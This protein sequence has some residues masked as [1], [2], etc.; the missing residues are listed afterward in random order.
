MSDN[1]GVIVNSPR[2]PQLKLL[3]REGMLSRVKLETFRRLSTTELKC[4]L[5]PGERGCLKARPDG[6]VLDGHHRLTVLAERGENIHQLPREII[7][8]DT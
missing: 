3:H 6:T 4:S 2:T 5:R 1:F 8:K 7:E